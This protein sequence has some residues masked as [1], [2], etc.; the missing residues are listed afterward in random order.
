MDWNKTGMRV[1]VKVKLRFVTRLTVY[2]NSY[3]IWDHLPYLPSAPSE[4]LCKLIYLA[5]EALSDSFEC[6]GAI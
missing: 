6:I 4:N 1:K 2:G 5:T 3:A